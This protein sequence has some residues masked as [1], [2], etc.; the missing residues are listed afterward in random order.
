MTIP[1]NTIRITAHFK[2]FAG[3]YADPTG[4]TFKVFDA[5]GQQVGNT[6]DLDSSNKTSTG[7]YYV[8]YLVPRNY[9]ELIYEMSGT[10]EGSVITGRGTLNIDN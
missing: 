10:L 3:N 4:I 2:T 7:I 9:D 5:F 6:V 1:N 8:D